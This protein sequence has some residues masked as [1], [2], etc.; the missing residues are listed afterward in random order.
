MTQAGVEEPW[1]Q[2]VIHHFRVVSALPS[3]PTGPTHAVE[4]AED[5]LT[6]AN[7]LHAMFPANGI[8]KW[9]LPALYAVDLDLVRLSAKV[10]AMA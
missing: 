10:Y 6:L 7:A 5:Q 2:L 4:L 9:A 3:S 8:Q 1:L